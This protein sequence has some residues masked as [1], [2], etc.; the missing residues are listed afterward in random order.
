MPARKEILIIRGIENLT[1]GLLLM[2][3]SVFVQVIEN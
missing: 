1:V 3:I 2:F